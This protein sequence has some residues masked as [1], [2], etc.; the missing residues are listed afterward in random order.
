MYACGSV[1]TWFG[2]GGGLSR[3]EFNIYN[4]AQHKLEKIRGGGGLQPPEPL[5]FLYLWHAIGKSWEQGLGMR[6]H[7]YIDHCMY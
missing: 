3:P 7:L 4:S 5:W 2:K 6:L 1:G